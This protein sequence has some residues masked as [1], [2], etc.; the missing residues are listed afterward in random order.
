MKEDFI[1]TDLE[2][3]EYLDSDKNENGFKIVHSLNEVT[4]FQT[5]LK[6]ELLGYKVFSDKFSPIWCMINNK[7]NKRLLVVVG[8]SPVIPFD[9]INKLNWPETFKN[10]LKRLLRWMNV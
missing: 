7:T 3:K 10:K 4:I 1:E 5:A 9:K 6:C 2:L 8:V